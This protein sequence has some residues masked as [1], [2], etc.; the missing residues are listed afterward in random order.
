MLKININSKAYKIFIDYAIKTCDLFSSVFEKSDEYALQEEYNLIS[1]GI[2]SKKSIYVHPDT[3]SCFENAD[4]CY[5]KTNTEV[6]S[7][8][9]KADSIFDW[10]GTALP[11]EL[12]FYRNREIWFSFVSHERLLFIHNETPN[13][14]EFFNKNKIGFTYEI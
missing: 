2:A 13:D 9:K 3:G 1:E 12:C 5:L 8:L 6:S 14:I 4:I 7:F 10:N 11:G